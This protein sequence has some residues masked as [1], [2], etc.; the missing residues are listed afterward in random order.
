M[1]EKDER[2]A[3]AVPADVALVLGDFTAAGLPPLIYADGPNGIRGAAGATAFPSSLAIAASFDIELAARHGRALGR[4]ARAAGRNGVLGPAMDLARVPTSGR[5]AESLGEDPL[6]AGELGGTIGAGIQAEGVLAVAKHFVANNFEHS[7]TG[8]GSFGRRSEAVDVRISPRALR[9]LYAEPFR[10]ALVRH[11]VM[12]LMGSYNRIAGEYVCE[13]APVL[14]IPR[15]EWGWTGVLMPD[16]LF[17]VRDHAAALTAGLDLP[18]LDAPSG[19]TAEHVAAED[20]A[21][22]RAL[23]G[24]IR[25]AITSVG[26]APIQESAPV[27]DDESLEL[28]QTEVELG[29]VLLRNDGGLLPLDADAAPHIALVGIEDPAPLLVMGGSAAV[30]LVGDRIRSIAEVLRNRLGGSSVHVEPGT[31]GDVPLPA[32]EGDV[33]ATVASEDGAEARLTLDRFELRDPPEGIGPDWSAVVEHRYTPTQSGEHRIAV[34]FAG[35]ARLLVDGR[36]VTGGFRE[37]SP[38]VEGP[39]Y[40][41]QA[42]VP[43]EQGRPVRIAL[44]YRTGPA[45]TIPGTPIRP[46]LRLGVAG[47]DGAIERAARAAGAADIA[48]VVVGRV[49]GE[50]MDV[51]S[52]RLPGDQ[53][54]LIDAVAGANTRTVVVVCAGG[55]VVMPWLDRVAAVLHVWNPGERFAPALDRMLFGDAEP[56]GRLPIT[57]PASED[58]TPVSTPERYP[59]VDG[60][61][62]YDEELLV[63]YRWYDAMDEDPAFP[64]GHGLGYTSFELSGLTVRREADTVRADVDVR[65]TGNRDGRVVVQAYTSSPPEAGLPPRSLRAFAAAWLGRG[66]HTR[67]SLSF[68]AD[69]LAVYLDGSTRTPIPGTHT[70][71]VGLSSRDLR[72]TTHFDVPGSPDPEAG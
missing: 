1:T 30:E 67:V 46:G 56:G 69:D 61:V 3:P 20:P 64:F 37:A 27:H 16:F 32:L 34:T 6:L 18:G 11:G 72:V 65:N 24:H 51:E 55:P 23:A 13:S 15:S 38:M 52:L 54:R 2:P 53:E 29:S 62:S 49:S 5:L 71:S 50:A 42:L 8:A 58:R 47:P 35:D 57:F 7:R 48:L 43:M 25:N 66:E 21:F 36:V 14:G 60:I 19:R 22:I 63:G 45:I 70:L 26:V 59:G 44:E 33:V 9:E 12:G 39:E 28:A 41:L 40:S 31:L 10:R 4:E 68:P 17:A